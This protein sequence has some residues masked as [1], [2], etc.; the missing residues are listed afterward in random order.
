VATVIDGHSKPFG[1]F[2][3]LT[4]A[5]SDET[6]HVATVVDCKTGIVQS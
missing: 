1:S 3:L 2:W 5:V 4:G 6:K